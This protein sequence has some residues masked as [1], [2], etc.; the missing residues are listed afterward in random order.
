MRIH[1]GVRART[2]ILTTLPTLGAL[3]QPP[4]G[5]LPLDPG[6]FP[7][8]ERAQTETHNRTL[9]TTVTSNGG[10]PPE[11]VAA[12]SFGP[13]PPVAEIVWAQNPMVLAGVISL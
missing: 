5:A 8:G 9:T 11:A 6:F 1:D 2:F 12:K 4:P 7:S 3:P 10:R 13:G